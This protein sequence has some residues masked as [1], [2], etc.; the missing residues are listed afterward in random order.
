MYIEED[1]DQDSS[2]Y[3]ALFGTYYNGWTEVFKGYRPN[4]EKLPEMYRSL[5]LDYDERVL[6]SIANEVPIM[7][8][9]AC[10]ALIHALQL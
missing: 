1:I 6:P 7:K 5:G 9:V 2:V 8:D 10:P 3:D 4:I